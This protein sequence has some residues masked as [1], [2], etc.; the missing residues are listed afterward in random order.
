MQEGGDDVAVL[1]QSVW[2]EVVSQDDSKKAQSKAMSVPA[3]LALRARF[4]EKG[5]QLLIDP[6]LPKLL[7]QPYNLDVRDETYNRAI[8]C[9][10][11]R[12][13]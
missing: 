11:V 4:L 5:L 12:P 13:R 9:S 3:P 8:S 10:L 2:I 6:Q 1:D 7:S